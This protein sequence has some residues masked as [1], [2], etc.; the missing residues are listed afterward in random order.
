[1]SRLLEHCIVMVTCRSLL[2]PWRAYCRL[3]FS[4]AV[5]VLCACCR[6]KALLG[7][8]VV[9]D[10]SQKR[11]C[12]T[13]ARYRIS[14]GEVTSDVVA[15]VGPTTHLGQPGPSSPHISCLAVRGCTEVTRA[16][17]HRKKRKETDIRGAHSPYAQ[18]SESLPTEEPTGLGSLSVHHASEPKLRFDNGVD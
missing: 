5:P 8:E 18:G 6:Q 2:A 4:Y 12:V 1:L 11:S 16:V 14:M 7:L 15:S 9:A 3:F 17:S 13:C 10:G